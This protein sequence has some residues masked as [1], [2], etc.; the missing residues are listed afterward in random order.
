MRGFHYRLLQKLIGELH[1]KFE[2][3]TESST[4]CNKP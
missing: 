3:N 4:K 1:L 2:T